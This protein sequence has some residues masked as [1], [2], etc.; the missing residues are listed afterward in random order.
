[1]F[2]FM[3]RPWFFVANAMVFGSVAFA[4]SWEPFCRAIAALMLAYFCQKSLAGNHSLLLDLATWDDEPIHNVVFVQVTACSKY[5][6]IFN[7]DGTEESSPHSIYVD[8]NLV[9]DTRYPM[10]KTLAAAAIFASMGQPMLHLRQCAVAMDKWCLLVVS[11]SLILLGLVFNT[12][13]MTVGVRKEYRREALHL[14]DTTW[15]PDREAFTAKEMELLV[16]K[17]G[18]IGQVYRPI[19]HLMLHMYAC[20]AYALRHN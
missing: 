16:G 1:M 8:D 9:A 19:Y 5:R 15:H 18:H 14:M 20:V 7:V 3:I 17:L 13:K 2:G 4:S 11:H 10:P 6:G 12:R